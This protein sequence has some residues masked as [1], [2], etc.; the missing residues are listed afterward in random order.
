MKQL[1]TLAL[2]LFS[3]GAMAQGS[4]P[5]NPDANENGTVGSED[6]LAFL[7]VYGSAFLPSGVLPVAGGGTGVSTLDS[8]RL[9][10]GVS[11]FADVIPL[12][13]SGPEAQ[14]T[15]DLRITQNLNQGQGNVA[16]GLYAAVSGRGGTASGTYSFVTNQNSTAT[17]T[18]SSAI[19][20]GTSATATAAHSQGFGSEA[21]GLAAHAEGYYTVASS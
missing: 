21:S 11:T 6:L 7:S 13:Q 15:G 5:Y 14:V 18:C 4:F 19:G 20:E 2:C 8:A 16:S 12:G 10:L 9:A 1:L 17:A 3:L